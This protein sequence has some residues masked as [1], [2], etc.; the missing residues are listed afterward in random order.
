MDISEDYVTYKGNANV[1]EFYNGSVIYLIYAKYIPSDPNYTRFGSMQITRGWIEEAGEFDVN[2]KNNLSASVGRWKNDKYNLKAKILQTCNPAKNYLYKDYYLKHKTG[3][4]EPHKKFI[5]ALPSDNKK[6]AKGYLE[7][8]NNV[9]SPSEKKRLLFGNWEY[10]DDPN[11]LCDY[12]SIISI[13]E[14]DHVQC[15][16]QKYITGDIARFGSDNYTNER[17]CKNDSL[18]PIQEYYC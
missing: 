16:G 11:A 4:L 12:E 7:H 14:N 10:D 18:N 17:Q 3:E 6:L 13:F 15:E 5:Q 1:F 8:L 2:A 9:L